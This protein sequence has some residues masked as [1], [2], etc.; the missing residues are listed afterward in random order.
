M[1]WL[2]RWG[3]AMLVGIGGIAAVSTAY[4]VSVPAEI[5][6][7]A[8]EAA[9]VYRLE[10]GVAVFAAGYVASLALVLALNNRAF[11]EL[12]TGGLKAQDIGGADQR[13]A[14]V[15]QG[16]WLMDLTESVEEL[17]EDVHQRDRRS[18]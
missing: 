4:S 5:P 1:D 12:G 11:A 7:F 13:T 17:R 2:A 10:V 18:G 6:S 15:E 9:P 8:L 16:E 3:F 14:I